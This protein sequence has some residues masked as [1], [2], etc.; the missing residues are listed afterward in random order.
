MAR[1]RIFRYLPELD[2]F[3][4]TPE[5]E[6]LANQIGLTEWNPVVWLGR[7][8]LMDNDFGEHWFD[9]WDAR[10]ERRALA[11]RH[12]FDADALLILDPERFQ[13]GRD[14]PCNTAAFRTRFWRDVLQS[15]ELSTDLLFDKAR[16]RNAGARTL[17]G[18]APL[19]SDIASD[20][21]PDLEERIATWKRT[22]T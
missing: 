22:Q 3:V 4:V 21:I 16:E 14:G 5:Y 8:F 10:D 9:N 12:G 6:A 13:D 1:L 18:S 7:L 17:L 2:A 15:L 19:D 20:Y 11:E